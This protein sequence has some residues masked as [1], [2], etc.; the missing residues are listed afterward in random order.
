MYRLCCLCNFHPSSPGPTASC[1]T[2]CLRVKRKNLICCDA[3]VCHCYTVPISACRS[4]PSLE[5]TAEEMTP[6]QPCM[7]VWWCFSATITPTPQLKV[8]VNSRKTCQILAFASPL[9]GTQT[10]RVRA[11]KTFSCFSCLCREGL[12]NHGDL[13][14]LAHTSEL[15]W[16]EQRACHRNMWSVYSWNTKLPNMLLLE[17]KLAPVESSNVSCFIF[18]RINEKLL[19]Q[20]PWCFRKWVWARNGV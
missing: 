12:S 13:F 6:L 8:S 14:G 15:E 19:W 4:T 3:P 5:N 10:V 11:Q 2:L 20:F 18:V 9:W 17:S 7:D 16:L 1:F